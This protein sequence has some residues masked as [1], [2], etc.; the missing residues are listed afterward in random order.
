MT[1]TGFLV[2]FFEVKNMI[3]RGTTPSITFHINTELDLTKIVEIWITFK[4]KYGAVNEMTYTIDDVTI[5]AENGNINL[6]LSQEDTLKFTDNPYD[7][8]IRLR[9]DDDLAYASAIIEVA[10]GRILKDGVI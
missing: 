3:I 10:I 8:Q 5:D 7:I 6:F 9:T 2:S 1:D 4:G